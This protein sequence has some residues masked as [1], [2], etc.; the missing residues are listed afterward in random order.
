MQQVG[1]KLKPITEEKREQNTKKNRQ[2]VTKIKKEMTDTET[3]TE[4]HKLDTGRKNTEKTEGTEWERQR[5]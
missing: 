3:H 2:A 4:T 1:E 5:G